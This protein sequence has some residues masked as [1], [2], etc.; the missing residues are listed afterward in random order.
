MDVQRCT[1]RDVSMLLRRAGNPRA[2]AASS[3]MTAVCRATGEGDAVAALR[4]VVGMALVG[5]DQHTVRVRD[6]IFRGDFERAAT[7]AQLAL[8]NGISRRHFQRWRARAVWT[9]ARYTREML[10]PAGAEPNSAPPRPAAVG[11]ARP[12]RRDA[13]WRFERERAEYL[14][15]RDAGA[16]LE[17]RAIAASLERLAD[18]REAR[19]LAARWRADA[20]AHLGRTED[21]RAR[22]DGLASGERLYLEAKLGILDG[23]LDAAEACAREALPALDDA[24]RVR[25]NALISQLRLMRWAPSLESARAVERSFGAWERVAMEVEYARHRAREGRWSDAEQ[26]ALRALSSAERRGFLGLAASSA[27]ALSACAGARGAWD[28]SLEWRARAIE[29]LLATQDCVLASGLFL[30]VNGARGL[31][32]SL[33]EVLYARLCLIVP[34]MLSDAPPQAANVRELLAALFDRT[35]SERRAADLTA[36]AAAVRRSDSALSH[37]LGRCVDGA[38]EM[39]ALSVAAIAQLPWAAALQRASGALAAVAPQMCPGAP[40]TIAISL[41]RRGRP[42]QTAVIEHLRVDDRRPAGSSTEDVANLR[43]RLVSLRAGTRGALPWRR[44]D[45]AVGTPVAAAV[46][47]DSR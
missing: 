40:R 7:N 17:M 16:T 11:C 23:D 5:D 22:L 24:D 47:A 30:R 42:S 13:A 6:A 14:R 1:E 38:A 21:A 3:L 26:A 9:I 15:A 4:H 34:Q 35:I 46:A 39:L 12:Q 32:A 19:A 29:R 18:G 36:A 44:G 10:G 28:E 20:S 2:L 37:Y 33:L 27:A 8:R 25:C 43:L 45:S 31:D 41:P